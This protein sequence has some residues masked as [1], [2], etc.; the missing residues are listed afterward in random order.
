[1][2]RKHMM[3]TIGNDS[4]PLNKVVLETENPEDPKSKLK[5]ARV[6][7]GNDS[8]A[9]VYEAAGGDSDAGLFPAR[10]LEAVKQHIYE[11][12]YAPTNA[13]RLIPAS[14]EKGQWIKEITFREY[15]RTGFARVMTSLADDAPIVNIRGREYTVK[16]KK[17]RA[18]YQYDVD[19]L[20]EAAHA[21]VPL[22]TKDAEAVVEAMEQEI[23]S[24]AWWGDAANNLPGLLYNPNI[25]AALVPAAAASPYSR[26]WSGKTSDEI[27]ADMT[28]AVT[29]PEDLTNGVETGIDTLCLPIKQYNLIKNRRLGLDSSS[30]TNET[31][32]SFFMK[33]N[34]GIK[35][36]KLIWLKAM[37][38]IP[39]SGAAGPVDC[40]LA[41]KKDPLKLTLEIPFDFWQAPPQERNLAFVVNCLLHYAG[42]L[43]Y[44]PLSI[45]LAEGI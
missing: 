22:L 37:P 4:V 35:I 23:E 9:E 38:T 29:A 28:F 7:I 33:N 13:R 2:K 25:T 3:V 19:E 18:A 39:S 14:S 42:V 21:N 40:M 15:D 45:Y 31:I 20:A 30:G 12:E 1:M 24:L 43:V 32:Y 27:V 5:W 36:E 17:I 26:A 6:L 34:P 16:V 11:I 41:Y 10:S 44:R 8:L